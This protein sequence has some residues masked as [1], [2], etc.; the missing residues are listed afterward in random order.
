MTIES[1]IERG[2]YIS[3][4]REHIIRKRKFAKDVVRNYAVGFLRRFYPNAEIHPNYRLGP[5]PE[6]RVYRDLSPAEIQMFGSY[7]P[8]VHAIGITDW[9]I[10]IVG[11]YRSRSY[12]QKGILKLP[13]L[14]RLVWETPELK[15]RVWGKFI[16]LVA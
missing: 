7:R 3:E 10:L 11:A 16:R 15:D 2:R 9:G 5:I 4:A 12:A 8:R 13:L 1:Q 14:S 6:S